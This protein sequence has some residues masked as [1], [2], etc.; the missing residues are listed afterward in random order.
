M[1]LLTID[2][3]ERTISGRN[4]NQSQIQC[5]GDIYELLTINWTIQLRAKGHSSCYLLLIL[6]PLKKVRN[7]AS[8]YK[9]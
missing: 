2:F 9:I 1:G 8:R 6:L 3:R 5:W 4:K 7:S